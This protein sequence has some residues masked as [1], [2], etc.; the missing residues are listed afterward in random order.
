MEKQE[1]T[2]LL[3]KTI[4]EEIN[5]FEKENQAEMLRLLKQEEE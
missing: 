3:L 5:N 2:A 4:Q 1:K